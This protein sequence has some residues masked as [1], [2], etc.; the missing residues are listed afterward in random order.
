MKPKSE[1]FRFDH[2]GL[3]CRD[4]S[5]TRTSVGG[6]HGIDAW[7]EVFQDPIQKVEVQFGLSSHAPV[8]ELIRP[9]GID[10]PIA[11]V[12]DRKANVLNHLAYRVAAMDEA[13][14]HCRALG[15]FVISPPA[16]AVAFGGNLI[17]F[18]YTPDDFIIE[19]IEGLDFAHRFETPTARQ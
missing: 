1:H 11:Q 19:L 4:F 2:L 16:P 3:V 6:I 8:I 12:L 18:L 7:S 13:I 14:E 17:C 15:Y 10:S 5:A 9:L